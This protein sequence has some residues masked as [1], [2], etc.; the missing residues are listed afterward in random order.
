M[1]KSVGEGFLKH[2]RLVWLGMCSLFLHKKKKKKKDNGY[3][4]KFTHILYSVLEYSLGYGEKLV[5]PT[6]K[7]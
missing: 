5:R 4:A 2:D 7:N 1:R 6:Q 3:G